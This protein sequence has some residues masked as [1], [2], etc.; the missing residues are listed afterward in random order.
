MTIR[1]LVVDDERPARDELVYLLS[2]HAD[3]ETME[4]ASA[5]E[6]LSLIASHHPDLV[7]QDIEMPGRGGFDVLQAAS[8]MTNPPVFVF[9]T[10]FDQ[11]A[12]RAFDENAADY[13][14]KPVAPERLARCLERVRQRLAPDGGSTQVEDMMDRLLARIGRERPLPRIAVEQGGRIHLV[15][16]P[17]VVLIEAEEKRIAVVTEAGRFTCHGAQSLARIEDRLAGQPFFRANRAVL[18]NLERVA[19]FSPWYNGKY[20]LVMNDSERTGVTV[21]RNRVRDFKQALG[22]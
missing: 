6:A 11:H 16:T 8:L 20:H 3:V 13:L 21:S 7:F 14:L 15:P 22:V 9:V 18:V 4:A 1:A 2:A 5:G 19:E 17:E 10:A 12:I